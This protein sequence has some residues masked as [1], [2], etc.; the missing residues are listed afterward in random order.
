MRSAS[1]LAGKGSARHQTR[2][3]RDALDQPQQPLQ[4]LAA[5]AQL[6]SYLL[7]KMKKVI[8]E[9]LNTLQAV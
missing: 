2:V 3:L 7:K 9:E 8:H 4:Q 5:T 6:L 1:Q